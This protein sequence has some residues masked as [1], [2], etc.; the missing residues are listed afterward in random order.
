M[1][2]LKIVL[3]AIHNLMRWIILGLG[4]VTL[5]RLYIGWLGKKKW[6]AQNHKP[7]MFF[8]IAL[9]IQ[10]IF[11]LLLYFIFSDLTK[12]AFKDFGNAMTIPALRF[13]TVEHSIIMVLAIISAH[14]GNSIA[15][16]HAEDHVK[17]RKV[18]I[19]YTIAILFLIIAIPW[20]TRPLLPG[21]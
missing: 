3:I 5:V 12:Q 18:A 21:L 2:T 16:Q 17:Y 7:G 20:T 10:L 4:V 19:A 13:F 9:D 8:S 11:G 15:K 6:L 14:I 1:E